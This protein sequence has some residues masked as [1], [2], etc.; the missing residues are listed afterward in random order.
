MTSGT[1]KIHCK[2]NKKQC[3]NLSPKCL[4]AIITLLCTATKATLRERFLR[5]QWRSWTVTLL[6]SRHTIHITV[7]E[8]LFVRYNKHSRWGTKWSWLKRIPIMP[9]FQTLMKRKA[10]VFLYLVGNIFRVQVTIVRKKC[11]ASPVHLTTL[12]VQPFGIFLCDSPSDSESLPSQNNRPKI[13]WKDQ[14]VD[15]RWMVQ[16]RTNAQSDSE[17][18][19]ARKTRGL[20]LLKISRR[21]KRL[22]KKPEIH[23]LRVK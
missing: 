11:V 14:D 19:Q 2:E 8:R 15:G 6:P 18:L 21:I 7:L 3:D 9:W 13:V 10:T 1:C 20:R 16:K 22:S 4:Y 5:F 23:Q 17:E 12:N